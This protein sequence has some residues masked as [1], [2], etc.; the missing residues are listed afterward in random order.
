VGSCCW[1]LVR[2]SKPVVD[3]GTTL[4]GRG[5]CPTLPSKAGGHSSRW[6]ANVWG[7]AEPAALPPT[8]PP[9]K[10]RS[11]CSGGGDGRVLITDVGSSLTLAEASL[12]RRGACLA[13]CPCMLRGKETCSVPAPPVFCSYLLTP[14][15]PQLKPA[16]TPAAIPAPHHSYTSTRTRP[17]PP[18]PSPTS[19]LL[20]LLPVSC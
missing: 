12:P 14:A 4:A 11:S 8:Y 20:Q 2:R 6:L 17:L 5:C 3:A 18:L 7:K 1:E 9:H 15:V 13:A 16:P 10:T 19:L